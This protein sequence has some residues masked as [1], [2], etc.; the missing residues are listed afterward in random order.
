MRWIILL[1]LAGFLGSCE[2]SKPVSKPRTKSQQAGDPGERIHD[3]SLEERLRY[4]PFSGAKRVDLVTMDRYQVLF[5]PKRQAPEPVLPGQPYP[6]KTLGGSSGVFRI[7]GV[8]TLSAVQLDSIT[9]ILFNYGFGATVKG[10][11]YGPSTCWNPRHALLFYKEIQDT[12]PF[13]SIEICLECN[14]I[15]TQP[16]AYFTGSYCPLKFSLFKS[17]FRQIGITYG[18]D[19]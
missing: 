9:N 16:E 8:Q 12:A 19:F 11:R 4:P 17:Y 1:L 15:A 10:E 13:A 2:S 5:N 7:L 3:L 6:F 14:Q 18:L